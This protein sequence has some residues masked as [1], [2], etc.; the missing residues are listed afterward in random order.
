MAA[1]RP[2]IYNTPEELEAAIDDYFNPIVENFIETST[3]SGTS[4]TKVGEERQPREKVTVSG[5]AFHLG[6][7]SR[8]SLYDYEEKEEFSYIVKKAR[9]RV[10][11]SY[12]ER[13]SEPACTGAI[14]ALKNM[15]WK[16]KTEVDNNLT[17]LNWNE[18]KTY[19]AKPQTD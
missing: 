16:D 3:K 17:V 11:M 13:L 1:G 6:F 8:Q 14:F 12:E 18:E 5:L 10:E 4:R 7:D 19:E 15:G 9:L 2:R